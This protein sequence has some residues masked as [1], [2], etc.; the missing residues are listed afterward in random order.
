MSEPLPVSVISLL[1]LL[2]KLSA[3]D[4]ARFFAELGAEEVMCPDCTKEQ[5]VMIGA[6]NTQACCFCGESFE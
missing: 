6:E 5:I 1:A 3:A 4:R 2:E